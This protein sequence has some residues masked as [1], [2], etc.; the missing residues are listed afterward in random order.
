MRED[1]VALTFVHT[2]DWHLGMRFRSF[3]EEHELELMRA[4]LDVIDRIFGVAD[5]TLADAVL[6]A[7]DLFDGPRPDAQWSEGLAA[8]LRKRASPKRPVFL[9]PGNH[10][11]L[12][13]DSVWDPASAFRKQLPEHVHVVDRDDFTFPLKEGAV[14]HAAPCRSSAGQKDLALSLPERA[15][16]D[17]RIRVGLV[18]GSTFDMKDCQTNFPIAQ[19]AAVRRGFD[20]LAI[21][22]THGFREVTPGA[23]Q[24]TV[25]PGAPEPTSF[26]ETDPGYVAVVFI[27]Q[28]RRVRLDR[29]RV[30]RWQWE[31]IEA[32]SLEDLRRLAAR[33][34]LGQRVVQLTVSASL[35]AAEYEEA[36]RLL[37]ELSGTEAV[38]PKVGIL[39][40]DKA[41]LVLDTRN[42]EA[43]F[44]NLPEA[45]REA[46]ARLKKEEDG[47]NADVARRALYHLYTLVRR[48][49]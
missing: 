33:T 14:L 18:H 39:R 15:P 9:L 27:T 36:E 8:V 11:P 16:A 22:D 41:R 20:Y 49:A 30:A 45:V 21:G 1:D 29:E 17:E 23:P 44:A 48:V 40:L 32:Q 5:S 43:V 25:Y 26:S 38:R 6:C 28:R 7:G 2:A 24:P 35:P 19:D 12:L 42:I 34:D 31:T 37:K 46:A 3:R 4:R 10:D 13:T 47:E